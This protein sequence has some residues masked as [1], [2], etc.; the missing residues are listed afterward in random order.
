MR[1]MERVKYYGTVPWSLHGYPVSPENDVGACTILSNVSAQNYLI[2]VNET[3]FTSIF[4]FLI[5]SPRYIN[6][7]LLHRG[8]LNGGRC[9]WF[10]LSHM[11]QKLR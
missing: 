9:D 7:R 5:G 4:S 1:L 8:T 3:Y 2:P 11:I 10:Y 6:T